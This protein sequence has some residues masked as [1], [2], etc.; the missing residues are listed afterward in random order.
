[1]S[2]IIHWTIKITW[3][4]GEEEYLSDIPDAIA[5]PT[6]GYLDALESRRNE[7]AKEKESE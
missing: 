7:K 2:K 5:K 6:D 1:M 4:D 3:S